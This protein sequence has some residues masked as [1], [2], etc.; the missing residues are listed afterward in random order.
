M[1]TYQ[2]VYGFTRLRVLVSVAEL[3]LGLV[4]LLV[5]AAGIR[6][7]AGWLPRTVAATG[8]VALLALAALNPDRFI[9]E[10]NLDRWYAGE[11]LDQAYLG[12]LSAD[13]VPALVCLP[14]DRSAVLARIRADLAASPADW[15]R[16]NLARTIAH[17]QL[18]GGPTDCDGR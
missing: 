2:E 9:A 4:F 11:P 8:I 1:H 12:G 18:T 17:A 13:A 3:W 14:P 15:R 16:A 5:L 7:R 10:R 6:L